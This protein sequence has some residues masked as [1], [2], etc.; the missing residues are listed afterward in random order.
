MLGA[1][2]VGYSP[3]AAAHA[4][5]RQSS[6]AANEVVGGAVHFVAMQFFDLDLD[7]P[8][9]AR[10]FDAAGNEIPAQL[11]QEGERLILALTDPIQSPGDY[12]VTFDLWGIDGDFSQESFVWTWQEGADEPK[13][14]TDLTEAA[15]F[16]TLNYVLVLIGAALAAFIV[17]RF[18]VALKEHRAYQAA[19]PPT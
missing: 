2:Q 7:Q 5:L 15:G 6:P 12:T 18:M 17:H 13:G 1:V 16:D 9:V 14:L 10:I 19:Q 11:N 3:D 4:E 8:Q